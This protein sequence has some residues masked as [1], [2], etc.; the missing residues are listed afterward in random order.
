MIGFLH[1]IFS[2]FQAPTAAANLAGAGA[3]G[4]GDPPGHYRLVPA[5]LPPHPGPEQK[6]ECIEVD[7]SANLHKAAESPC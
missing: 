3:G 7:L 4:P 6:C 2:C 1:I 5:G